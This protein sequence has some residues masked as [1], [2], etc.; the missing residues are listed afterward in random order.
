MKG[1][2]RSLLE[3]IIFSVTLHRL[4]D[5]LETLCVPSDALKIER[6]M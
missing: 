5:L 6:T 2:Q 3:G 4:K 1:V